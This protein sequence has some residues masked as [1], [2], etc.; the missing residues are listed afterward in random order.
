M[1]DALRRRRSFAHDGSFAKNIDGL[2]GSGKTLQ[3]RMLFVDLFI[4]IGIEDI[5]DLVSFDQCL[6]SGNGKNN[7]RVDLVR[8]HDNGPVD[9]AQGIT[10]L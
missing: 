6:V 1:N 3:D 9:L 8:A 5:I 2:L 7:A 4:I 10:R